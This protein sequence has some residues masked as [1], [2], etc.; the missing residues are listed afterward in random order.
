[1]IT[2]FNTIYTLLSLNGILFILSCNLSIVKPCKNLCTV[3][4]FLYSYL[5]DLASKKNYR[6]WQFLASIHSQKSYLNLSIF[7]LTFLAAAIP[8]TIRRGC[9][10]LFLWPLRD[11]T[12]NR[13]LLSFWLDGFALLVHRLPTGL[14]SGLNILGG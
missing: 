3:I 5:T 9:S 6:H 1:M 2:F 13:V 7:F 10:G 8:N 11:L 12:R 14:F 4:I